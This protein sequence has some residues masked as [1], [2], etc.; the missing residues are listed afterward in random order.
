MSLKKY[1]GS[2]HCGAVRYE[3]DLDLSAGTGRCN[4]SFCRKVRNWS[5]IVKPEAFRLLNGENSL[6]FYEFNTKS[7]KHHFCKNCGVRTFSKGYIEEIGGAFISV[8]I[9]TLDNA[10][11]NELIEA[12]VWYAD[13]L[14]N[15]WHSQP[16]EIR[17]L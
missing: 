5:I 14:N 2:C 10:D 7:S 17:Y 4:C 11:L 8:A 15:N 12:P 3:A 6:S 1:T 13:G 9:S 16:A